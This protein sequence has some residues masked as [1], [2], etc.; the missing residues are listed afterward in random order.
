MKHVLSAI[1][2]L[3]L[4]CV[5]WVSDQAQTCQNEK[6]KRIVFQNYLANAYTDHFLS[7]YGLHPKDQRAVA[8]SNK[9]ATTRRAN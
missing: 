8:F 5:L 2:A 7:V 4:I 6:T 1:S 3:A 9:Q